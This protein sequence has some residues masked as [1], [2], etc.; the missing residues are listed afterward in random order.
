MINPKPETTGINPYRDGQ[1]RRQ[2]EAQGHGAST[3]RL[4]PRPLGMA[5]SWFAPNPTVSGE[6]KEGNRRSQEGGA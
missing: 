4:K 2:T 5:P 1:R 6:V 3:V